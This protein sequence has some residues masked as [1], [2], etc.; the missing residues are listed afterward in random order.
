M[1]HPSEK[2]APLV[3]LPPPALR[4]VSVAHNWATEAPKDVTSGR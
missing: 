1:K 3:T 4:R 2:H